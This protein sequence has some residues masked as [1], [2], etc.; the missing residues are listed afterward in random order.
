MAQVPQ[1]L[2]T[3]CV[4]KN[5]SKKMLKAWC[6]E[7]IPRTGDRI[8]RGR[9]LEEGIQEA[10]DKS[11]KDGTEPGEGHKQERPQLTLMQKWLH[12]QKQVQ[13]KKVEQKETK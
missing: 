9:G 4:K 13:S 10:G 3:T 11:N 8:L 6:L 5:S 12:G 7:N 2:L 1:L